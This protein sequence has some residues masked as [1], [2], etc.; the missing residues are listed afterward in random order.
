MSEWEVAFEVG[1]SGFLP[2][3]GGFLSFVLSPYLP[4]FVPRFRLV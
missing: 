4:I 2:I 3:F 1:F